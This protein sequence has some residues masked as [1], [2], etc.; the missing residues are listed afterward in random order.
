MISADPPTAVVPRTDGLVRAIGRWTMVAL[1]INMIVGAGIFGL[2]A[3]VHAQSGPYALLAYA[4]C[5]VV[6]ACIVLCLAEVASR[7]SGSGGPFLYTTEAFGPIP[8][9]LVGWLMVVTRMT[10]LAIIANVM[11]DYLAYF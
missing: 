6:I 4:V 9:F 8:G 2:P 7:F 11:A 10:S 3:R 1:T 5:A